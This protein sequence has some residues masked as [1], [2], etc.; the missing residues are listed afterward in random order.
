VQRYV[1][2]TQL[3]FAQSHS[4][5][6]TTCI[7]AAHSCKKAAV[8][9]VFVKKSGIR[10]G[11]QVLVAMWQPVRFLL[12]YV[13]SLFFYA[14]VVVR[15]LCYRHGI[16]KS[17]RMPFKVISIGN[18]STGG[19][20]KTPLAELLIRE[21]LNIG[22]RPAYLSR[23]YGRNTKGYLRVETHMDVA[24]VGD[25]ALQVKLKFPEVPLAVCEKR[26]LGA[27]RLQTEQPFDVLILDDAFQHR[28]IRRDLDIVT[29]DSNRPPWKDWML[30]LGLLREPTL[31]L[32]R[33]R[34]VF[35]NNILDAKTR[36]LYYKRMPRARL[37]FTR[38]RVSSLRAINP[39]QP[40]IAAHDLN[41][42]PAILFSGLGNNTKFLITASSQGIAVGRFYEFPD[43]HTYTF[44]D[45]K[46]VTRRF[47]RL[48]KHHTFQRKPIILTTEKDY[49]RLRYASWFT[50]HFG[51]LPIYYLQ[52][53]Q[54]IVRGEEY[55]ERHLQRLL[56]RIRGAEDSVMQQLDTELPLAPEQLGDL[57]YK[58]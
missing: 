18:L 47:N 8:G 54:E 42:R 53:E 9:S 46:R 27:R 5:N 45:L 1:R 31:S 6:P 38:L 58:L 48:D 21:L 34:L 28:S 43:H 29:I 19:T 26:V 15:N 51:H 41:Q 39:N 57:P 52:V 56:K 16:L 32:R 55:V 40:D 44:N 14:A 25:E 36:E 22:L 33:A 50:Q 37:V 11:E 30:P 2:T 12:L 7:F 23:G 20:G 17:Y 24:A 10:I 35:V 49:M 4:N 3:F 13:P